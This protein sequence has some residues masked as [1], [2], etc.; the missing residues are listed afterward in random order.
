MVD[1]KSKYTG[2]EV[3]SIL[4]AVKNIN[5]PILDAPYDSSNSIAGFVGDNVMKHS[6]I[7]ITPDMVEVSIVIENFETPNKDVVEYIWHFVTGTSPTLSLPDY[8]YWPNGEMPE[9][10]DDTVYELSIT[11]TRHYPTSD[12][13]YKAVLVPFKTI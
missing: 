12:Y 13:I 6:V 9:I 3:E 8:L 2:E 10:E 7:Y 11:A 4:D 1:Y 5:K